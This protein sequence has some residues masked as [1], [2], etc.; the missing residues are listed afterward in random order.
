MKV[1]VAT[2]RGQGRRRGDFCWT[3]EGE[4]VRLPLALCDCPDCGCDR[5]MAGLASSKATTT[6]TVA[7]RDDL[8][9]ATYRELVRD[10]LRRDGLIDAIGDGGWVTELADLQ[11]LIA[12]ELRVGVELELR[13][14]R[15]VAVRLPIR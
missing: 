2:S 7:E 11:L 4:L 13:D 9:A 1:L 14:G 6:F 10:A 3:V 15:S 8:D 12:A 5:A